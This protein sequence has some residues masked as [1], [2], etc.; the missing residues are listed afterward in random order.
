MINVVGGKGDLISLV[1]RN[2]FVP[3]M[4]ELIKLRAQRVQ[5]EHIRYG[6]ESV[7]D[8]A[9][10]TS[11]NLP[12]FFSHPRPKARLLILRHRFLGRNSA[13]R[14]AFALPP[15]LTR[16][17]PHTEYFVDMWTANDSI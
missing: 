16:V 14:R 2:S 15:T 13:A 1:Q 4:R 9:C 5:H 12:M 7:S 17:E 3:G 6:G 10:P 11:R 8:T